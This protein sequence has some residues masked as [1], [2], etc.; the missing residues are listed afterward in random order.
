MTRPSTTPILAELQNPSTYP[1]QLSALKTLRNEVIGQDQ[2]KEA[3]IAAG[4]ITP[5]VKTLTPSRTGGKRRSREVNGGPGPSP[6][7]ESIVP[8]EEES[9]LQAT[10]IIGSLAQG[11]SAFVAPLL[12]AAAIPALLNAISPADNCPKLVLA[13]LRA[14]NTIADAITLSLPQPAIQ[15]G[16]LTNV[17]F[18]EPHVHDLTHILSQAS[19]SP[20]VQLQID[21]VAALIAKTCSEDWHQAALAGAGA[22]DALAGRLALF[23]IATRYVPPA[24]DG[25][26]PDFRRPERPPTAKLHLTLQAISAIIQDSRSRAAH[27]L[28]SG[29]I[30]VIFPSPRLERAPDAGDK[31][32][33]SHRLPSPEEMYRQMYV[34]SIDALLPPVPSPHVKGT[35]SSTA[36]PPLGPTVSRTL[37][38][39]NLKGTHNWFSDQAPGETG[40]TAIPSPS[41]CMNEEDES[42]LVPWLIHLTRAEQGITRLMSAGVLTALYRAGLMSKK[43]E[44]TLALLVIPILVQM[45]DDDSPA[46]DRALAKRAA[47]LARWEEMAI[48]ERTPAILATLVTDSLELQRAAVEA[49]A[50][51]KL[52][53]MLKV[54]YDPIPRAAAISTWTPAEANGTVTAATDGL[55]PSRLGRPGLAAA[56]LH[57]MSVRGSTLKAL[58]ALAPFRDEY[59]KMIIDH[60]VA[61]F[62]VESLV[63][64]DLTP[65]MPYAA[66]TADPPD[67]PTGRAIRTDPNT[68]GKGNPPFVLIAACAAVRAL[69]RS[70][71]ILRTS[72]IDAGV[73]MPLF[74]LLKHDDL[75]VQIAATAAVCNL[76]LEFSPMRE[77]SDTSSA[78]R[79]VSPHLMR[80]E[81]AIMRAGI[82]KILC[83]HA[84]SNNTRLRLNALWALKNLVCSAENAIK[85]TCLQELGQ[86]WLIRLICDE[87][88]R[89]ALV[90]QGQWD[91]SEA[92]MTEE[93]N[94]DGEGDAS[95]DL[96]DTYPP[97]RP[98]AAEHVPSM[99]IGTDGVVSLGDGLDAP[100]MGESSLTQRAGRDDR[101][102]QEQGLAFI[103]NLICGP[104]SV[105]MIDFLLRTLGQDR[106]F[107]ILSSKLRPRVVHGPDRGRRPASSQGSTT[108]VIQPPGEI[109]VAVCFI[110]V[111]IAASH[112]RHRQLLMSQTELLNLL[113]PLFGHANKN[114]RVAL[115]WIIINLTWLDDQA[116]QHACRNRALELKRL[117]FQGKLEALEHD[118]ELDVRERT[119]TAL[120]QIKQAINIL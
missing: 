22:L 31:Q 97:G 28:Y 100:S 76:V 34:R 102:V 83:E 104:E 75:E 80:D 118:P 106:L 82:L 23:I 33:P 111:H 109:I 66:E 18:A 36:F 43:R 81:Q 37:P 120:S 6:A 92:I 61:P 59:R 65:E 30:L 29:I 87:S 74:A 115:T 56:T 17:L 114:V 78:R 105:E 110:L 26:L 19:H 119:K 46:A 86:S 84:H 49:N 55:G 41:L 35:T 2:R 27:F 90:S 99:A 98:A 14:L 77:V 4:I 20:I 95:L 10:I 3:W 72:L 71:S 42:P 44:T 8:E 91:S 93:G 12:Q 51:K 16:V 7:D 67:P 116:D 25:L 39:I 63:P 1:A 79:Q 89:Q 96:R 101:A 113:M 40:D 58:A 11:G 15:D 94:K 53:H 45:L 48:R 54:A 21:Q 68:N 5:L 47:D 13:T 38:G 108:R 112:P 60:G 50:I 85:M 69:S 24:A 52:A 9:R 62:L 88:E 103:R 70:V 57:Q 64:L 107:E 117:G 73:A 32:G